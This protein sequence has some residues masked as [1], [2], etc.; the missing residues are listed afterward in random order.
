MCSPWL[1]EDLFREKVRCQVVIRNSLRVKKRKQTQEKELVG[2][3]AGLNP[4]ELSLGG[5]DQK[6][7]IFYLAPD[8]QG[9][10]IKE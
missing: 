3:V 7:R 5:R 8:A 6:E 10:G 9:Q 1:I 4:T 2:L